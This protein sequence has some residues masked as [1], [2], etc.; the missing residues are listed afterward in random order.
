MVFL[1]NQSFYQKIIPIQRIQGIVFDVILKKKHNDI[2][3]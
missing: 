3:I 2:V 1:V